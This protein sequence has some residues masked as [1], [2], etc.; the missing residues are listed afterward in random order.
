MVAAVSNPKPGPRNAI[1]DVPGI[2]VGQAHDAALK[3]GVS[4]IQCADS[5]NCAVD[6]RGGGPGT[7][8]TDALRPE[9]LVHKAHAIV[10]TGGSVFGL[11]SADAVTQKLTTQGIG[12][13]LQPGAKH[14]PIVP[15]AVLHD[16]SSGKHADW[17]DTPPYHRLGGEALDA[18]C[19][20]V[21]QGSVG[22]GM[23][24][25]AGLEPGGVGTASLALSSGI[26]C[27]ALIAVNP[28]GSVRMPGCDAF[29][30][31]P[32]EIDKEFGG[33]SAAGA[34]P[35][36]EPFADMS[37]LSGANKLLAGGNT[38]I[39]V[40]AVNADLTASECQRVAIMAQDGIARA[41]RPAHTPFDGD[42]IF[43]V[44]TG[45]HALGDENRALFVAQI[46]A[47][48]ADCVARAIA[49]GVYY[50]A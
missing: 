26:V 47:A 36:I 1:T 39:G 15:A 50:A 6:V 10:L 12:L 19:E 22:A 44:A 32:W 13:Q 27:G 30:A 45:K 43:A 40:A 48:L 21:T 41:V 34:A 49:K 35:A 11:A 37:R 28:A 9:N 25:V 38:T 2:L 33:I 20:D 5:V 46:G 4:V 23:G 18:L 16:L 31:H 24:A 7:R 42:T 29:W 14:I 8:E 3:T 17:G